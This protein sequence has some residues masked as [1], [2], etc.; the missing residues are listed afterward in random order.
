MI[1]FKSS[2]GFRRYFYFG[3]VKILI[4]RHWSQ[5]SEYEEVEKET[6]DHKD[7]FIEKGG[8][9]VLNTPSTRHN[10]KCKEQGNYIQFTHAFMTDD[11]VSA[12]YGPREKVSFLAGVCEQNPSVLRLVY[13][14]PTK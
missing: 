14:N 4:P 7:F 11:D 13:C 9:G 6:S 3:Q 1:E 10:G 5:K 8:P 2:F 12:K